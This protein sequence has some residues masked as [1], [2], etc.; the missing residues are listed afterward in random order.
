[1]KWPTLQIDTPDGIKD[2]IAPL[3]ISASR[4]T[5]IPAFHSDWFFHRLSAGYCV[6]VNP[7]N[8][9]KHYISFRNA[10]AVV[11]WSKNPAPLLKRLDEL[12]QFG[13]CYYFQFT[14]NDYEVERFEP[15]V[16]A[17]DER[18][19]T[20]KLLSK[21]IGKERVIWRFD[22]II[23]AD[24]LTCDDILSRI[25]HIGNRLASYT[26]KLVISFADINVYP[27]VRRH[28]QSFSI[29]CREPMP[30]EMAV[31]A[32][33]IAEFAR[34]WKMSV[35]SCCETIDLEQF[36]IEHNRCVDPDLLLRLSSDSELIDFITDS[37]RSQS[38]LEE[39]G[40]DYN[41]LKDK[42]QR[43]RCGCVWSKDIGQYNTCPHYCVYCY[44][45]GS[46]ETVRKN[47]TDFSSMTESILSRI[48]E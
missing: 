44:A 28:L 18:I 6:W 36:G 13:F 35:S 9:K 20:F 46:K 25:R 29:L 23:L 24:T 42:G 3:I 43:T 33:Q 31:M 7:Y 37:R 32:G 11:F 47:E 5:D 14:L 45:N 40:L 39:S 2:A 38:L 17:L 41:A 16:P 27:K 15:N 8:N 4:A 12:E 30:S 34:D 26:Q 22:P 48:A 1:M 10:K 21:R 19:E